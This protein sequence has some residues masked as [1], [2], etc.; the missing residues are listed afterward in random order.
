[1]N[2]TSFSQRLNA[3]EQAIQAACDQAGR[4]RNEV[5]LVGV[6]K[7]HPNTALQEAYDAGLRDFGENYIQEWRQKADDLATTCPA[8]RWHLIGPLQRNKCK[9][10]VGRTAWLHT[11]DSVALLQE[12]A[13]RQPPDIPLHA[14]LQC[15]VAH[16][17]QKS[18]INRIEEARELLQQAPAHIVIQGLMV[19]PPL[20]EDPE[21]TRPFFQALRHWRDQLQ[22]QTGRS[23][24]HLSMG[25][26]HDFAVAIQEGATFV[27]VGTALF[28]E[29][30][31][32]EDSH[33][34]EDS[35]A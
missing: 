29:R 27:R 22:E 18:G 1:M 17:S 4:A 23:L 7:M 12:L 15:N 14:L 11:L 21:A 25:M 31:F 5:T 33:P 3:I 16:E 24:P 35:H 30:P 20:Y 6:S 19:I 9:Y 13:K 2:V 28:G 26:S 8:L 34:S 10:I 32:H